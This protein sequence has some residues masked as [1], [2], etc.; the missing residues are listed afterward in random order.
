MI[1]GMITAVITMMV[2]MP[3]DGDGGSGDDDDDGDDAADGDDGENDPRSH[4]ATELRPDRL[5]A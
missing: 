5:L 2:A 1:Y 4:D 3:D